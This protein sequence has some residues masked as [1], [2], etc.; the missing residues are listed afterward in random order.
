MT[1]EDLAF[2]FYTIGHRPTPS[3]GFPVIGRPAGIAGL[4]LCVMH[5][6]ITLAPAV[7]LFAAEEI[8][9]GGRDPLLLPY[10]PERFG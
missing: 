7:G 1:P 6:G 10:G 9:T 2:D 5:S 8:L 4:Y 3:D